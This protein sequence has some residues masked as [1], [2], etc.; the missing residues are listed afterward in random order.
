MYLRFFN[1]L[2]KNQN[3]DDNTFSYALN[4]LKKEGIATEEAIAEHLKNSEAP[5]ATAPLSQTDRL[6]SFLKP[7]LAKHMR[8]GAIFSC[9]LEDPSS[10]FI[11]EKFLELITDPFIEYKETLIPIQVPPH[12]N[13]YI[14]N[15]ALVITVKKM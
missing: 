14:G 15:Q 6:F 9:Y 10:K 2:K 12:C 8:K 4:R 13:Y 5:K 3:I 1:D 11:D 7:C